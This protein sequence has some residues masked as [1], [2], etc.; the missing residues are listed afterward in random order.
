MLSLSAAAILEK[1]KL[2]SD[3]AWL[4]LLEVQVPDGTV[5]RFARNTED[6]SWNGETWVAFPFEL[7]VMGEEAKGEIP[8]VSIQVSNVTRA[9]QPYLESSGGGVGSTAII[10]VVH[11]GHLDMTT[12]ELEEL[13][14]VTGV[15]VDAQ[16]V[17]FTLGI[18]YPTTSRRP[19]RRNLKNFCPFRYGSVECG[20][21]AAALA[22]YPACGKTLAD[23]R[24]R[25]NSTRY[26]G[27][28]SIPQGGLYA[29]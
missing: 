23:C 24:E 5:L 12:P 19:S 14:S 22:A 7:S 26:G 10:R 17:T 6:V 29:S 25:D 20:V 18:E 9:V 21:S 3:G 11:S 8:K 4:I 2:A 16:W 13:Y 1:N 15:K 28:P 27:E